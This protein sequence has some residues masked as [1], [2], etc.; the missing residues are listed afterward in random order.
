[1]LEKGWSFDSSFPNATGDGLKLGGTHIRD[2]YFKVQPD[3]DARFT[4]VLL[5]GRGPVCLDR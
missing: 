1:M 4:C 2:V 5:P 3:Y